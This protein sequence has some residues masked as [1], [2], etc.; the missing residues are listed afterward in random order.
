MLYVRSMYALDHD[1]EWRGKVPGDRHEFRVPT[2]GRGKG[3]RDVFDYF[4]PAYL[5]GLANLL[6]AQIPIDM[7]A[8]RR[9]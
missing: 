4:A 1:P 8:Q 5:G 2:K 9:S 7:Q 3:V 6:E